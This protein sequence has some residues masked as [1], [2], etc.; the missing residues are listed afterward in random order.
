MAT[1]NGVSIS[2]TTINGTVGYDTILGDADSET[3]YGLD[4]GD[5][6]L[7]YEG[8]DYL[9]GGSGNDS[10][11][12]GIGNDTLLGG[13]SGNDTLAGGAGKDIFVIERQA[14]GSQSIT[15]FT[16]GEDQLDFSDFGISDIETLQ[17]LRKDV[18]N[19]LV[20]TINTEGSYQTITLANQ[21]VDSLTTGDVIL[22]TSNSNDNLS[23]ARKSD[24][25]GGIGDDTLTGSSYSD[26]LFGEAGNDTL[27][28]GSGEDYII[29]GVGDDSLDGGAF[30]DTLEGG[31][32]SDHF[33]LQST[34]YASDVIVDF[35]TSEGDKLDVRTLGIGDLD[36]LKALA[37]TADTIFIYRNGALL[38]TT[39]NETVIFSLGESNVLL[40]ANSTDDLL[41]VTDQSDLFGAAGNDTLIGSTDKDR[42]FG[43]AGNDSLDGGA[44]Y[45]TLNGGAGNDTLNGGLYNDTVL[46][47]AGNDRFIIN[48]DNSDDRMDG[49]E[50]IDTVDYSIISN[51]IKVDLRIYAKQT[52]VATTGREDTIREIEN[53]V[54]GIVADRI[55][56]SAGAN[57]LD[58][59]TGDDIL[60]GYTGNDTLIGGLGNDSLN[61]GDGF[62]YASYASA[63]AGVTIDLRKGML[64]DAG[65][66]AAVGADVLINI[67]GLIG[68]KNHVDT[69]IGNASANALDGSNDKLADSLY[70]QGGNDTY[71]VGKGDKVYE[72]TTSSSGID[73]GGI[74]TVVW[75]D[76][77]GT[78]TLGRFIEKLH[79]G[80]GAAINGTGNTLANTLLG[81]RGAN[82]LKGNGGNDNLNGGAGND[83]L[84][85]GT[86]KDILTGGVGS[87]IFDFNTISEMG[88]AETAR[89]VI[90]DFVHGQDRIDLSTL[91]A[92]TST[93]TDDSFNSPTVGGSFSG[94]FASPGDLY[95]DDIAKVLYGNTDADA[96]AEFA[97]TLAGI[98]TLS[99][100]DI[101]F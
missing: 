62:D 81:N 27:L 30:N 36:T 65:T 24:L 87:D 2:G 84:I 79:L 58:G 83:T 53:V 17:F 54:G 88:V 89:D 92:D 1:L 25:F 60:S 10:L 101:I 46:G 98:S 44:G 51:S 23:A 5:T 21:W 93:T 26:R 12:G 64:T 6:I 9:S 37:N 77:I 91:D 32:G 45:D 18:S 56:G 55:A 69:L 16:T 73:A 19:A 66:I 11:S 71:Y 85:G 38:S 43:E 59:N 80:G 61:G 40:S 95:F 41:S 67:E 100:A 90:T 3:I 57:L 63:S 29:G 13:L 48:N 50:G 35:S 75:N 39:L 70:G 78:Y 28:G 34:G 94:N 31:N 7:G 68:S 47:G 4:G 22:S 76:T 20:Y 42:L 97:I 99:E 86:G 33:V 49:G 72:T 74:D 96:D 15:D 82:I 14:Y 52:V 8:N